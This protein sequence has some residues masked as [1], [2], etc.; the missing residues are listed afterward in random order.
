MS[1][2]ESIRD[3]VSGMSYAIEDAVEKTLGIMIAICKFGWEVFDEITDGNPWLAIIAI[4][5]ITG[6]GYF[7]Y[8]VI[9]SAISA[10]QSP[11]IK[12]VLR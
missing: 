7:V 3:T 11:A 5:A 12:S 6:I 1:V 4:V 10:N 2:I 8:G 9:D